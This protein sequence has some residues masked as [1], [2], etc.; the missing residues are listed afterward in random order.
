MK[1]LEA[2]CDTPEGIE[3]VK[4]GDVCRGFMYWVK[5]PVHTDNYTLRAG[6]GDPADDETHYVPGKN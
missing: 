5:R 1:C 4:N 6:K 3:A 2:G